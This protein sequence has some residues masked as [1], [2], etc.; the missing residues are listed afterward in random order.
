[1]FLLLYAERKCTGKN[2]AAN[3][4][5]GMCLLP[6]AARKFTGENSVKN[7]SSQNKSIKFERKA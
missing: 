5:E 6:Y 4:N 1:M 2:S 3:K 7:F